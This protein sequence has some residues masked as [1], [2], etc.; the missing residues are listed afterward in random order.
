M[1]LQ[2]GYYTFLRIIV[3]LMGKPA[4]C[5]YDFRADYFEIN[6]GREKSELNMGNCYLG[7]DLGTGLSIRCIKD[8]C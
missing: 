8:S 2:I 7:Y 5:Y 4:F 3:A 6:K 1:H